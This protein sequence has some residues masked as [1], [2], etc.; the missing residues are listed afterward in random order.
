MRRTGRGRPSRETE[1]RTLCVA[2]A[3]VVEGRGSLATSALKGRS[4]SL[5]T[6]TRQPV[7]REPGPH[8]MPVP[9]RTAPG[10]GLGSVPE[11][12]E[13]GGRNDP[14][15]MVTLAEDGARR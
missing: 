13:Q 6:P 7:N 12:A 3:G 4:A 14:L 10:G 2:N 11:P 1:V 15:E 8:L 9:P 5:A